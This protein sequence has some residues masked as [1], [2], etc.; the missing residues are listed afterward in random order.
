MHETAKIGSRCLKGEG[1][2][3]ARLAIYVDAPNYMDDKRGRPFISEPADLLKWMLRRMSIPM[4]KV[5][6]DYVLKCYPGKKVPTKKTEAMIYIQ[7][8]NRYR[9]ATLQT[10]FPREIVTFGGLSM[11]AF[12][13]FAASSLGDHA[14]AYW[15]PSDPYIA[16]IVN[17][18]WTG[19]SIGYPLQSPNEAHSQ[20]G[21][22]WMAAENAGLNPTI[23]ET[24][25]PY[26]KFPLK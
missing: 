22:L 2:V 18:I 1:G 12:C 20:F 25:K 24:V 21:L 7:Q 15:P 9:I 3:G 6:L 10:L 11:L 8:C 14:N 26:T 23:D 16:A 13:G 19:Y 4:D 5:Y 17:R